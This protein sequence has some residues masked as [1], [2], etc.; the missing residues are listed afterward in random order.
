MSLAACPTCARHHDPATACPFCAGAP[1]DAAIPAR[2]G[3]A[4]LLSAATTLGCVG[5]MPAAPTATPSPAASSALAGSLPTP[6]P[7]PTNTPSTTYG[8]PP[9]RR[10]RS[11]GE[12]TARRSAS[13]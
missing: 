9:P 2:L 5:G 8:M 7:A 12:A 11:P 10:R 3:G 4:L 13:G 1:A 6:T